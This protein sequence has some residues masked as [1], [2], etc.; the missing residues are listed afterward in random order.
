MKLDNQNKNIL[1]LNSGILVT[2]FA[3]LLFMFI[4][5]D[6]SSAAFLISTMLIAFSLFEYRKKIAL[7]NIFRLLVAAFISVLL[8]ISFYLAKDKNILNLG[9]P[10]EERVAKQE[11]TADELLNALSKATETGASQ[12]EI[13]GMLNFLLFKAEGEATTTDPKSYGTLGRSYE[14]AFLLGDMNA[15]QKAMEAYIIYC[16]LSPND[17][18][19]YAHL[20]RFI[21]LDQT[22][23]EEAVIYAK[24]ALSLS[25]TEEEAMSYNELVE[26]FLK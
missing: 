8:I 12:D 1:L 11:L 26:Y 17:P 5:T 16:K 24:K 9:I 20:A 13:R 25:R 21:G 19:C 7:R 4:D 22:K 18:E 14:A 10:E 23:R 6:M 15:D 2:F 3:G